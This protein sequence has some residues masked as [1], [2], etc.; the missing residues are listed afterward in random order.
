MVLAM[1]L[2]IRIMT[3]SILAGFLTGMLFDLY[4]VYRGFKNLKIIKIIEDIL[5]W[6]LATLVV[7]NFLLYT[8]YAFISFYVYIFIGVGI[9]L[10]LKIFSNTF[11]KAYN[12]IGKSIYKLFRVTLKHISYP[13][14]LLF[15]NKNYKKVSNNKKS[16]E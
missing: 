1:D 10:Y 13:F 16:L 6:I 11:V 7:F 15:Y 8:N 9:L 14:K 12:A 5:F 3:F 2:Q 4:R